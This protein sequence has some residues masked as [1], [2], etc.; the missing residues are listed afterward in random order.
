MRS[1]MRRLR[2]AGSTRLLAGSEP[3]KLYMPSS[4]KPAILR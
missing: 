3:N 1:T 4:S 2:D